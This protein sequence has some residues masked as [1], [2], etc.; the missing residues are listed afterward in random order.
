MK[1]TSEQLAISIRSGAASELHLIRW[2]FIFSSPALESCVCVLCMNLQPQFATGDSHM[3]RTD[4]LL[5]DSSAHLDRQS[6]Q[7][8]CECKLTFQSHHHH[9]HQSLNHKGCWGTTDDFA[10][11][12][13]HFYPVLHHPLGLAELQDC[14]FPDVVFP[15]LPLSALSSSPFHCA[16][17]DFFSRL[18]EREI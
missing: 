18:D 12:F 13:L 17:Q 15:P 16:L 8:P 11:S 4:L 6:K 9:H 3:C 5:G 7:I 14:P 2:F 10:T 1:Q